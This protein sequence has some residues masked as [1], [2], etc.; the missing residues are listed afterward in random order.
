MEGG[1]HH[2]SKEAEAVARKLQPEHRA[3]LL[4]AA[5]SLQSPCSLCQDAPEEAVITKCCHVFCRQ[6]IAEQVDDS[7]RTLT[8]YSR[9][10]FVAF[11]QDWLAA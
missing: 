10:S 3:A 11:S 8:S 5:E 1:D 4:A 7:S 6:C 9:L 2:A